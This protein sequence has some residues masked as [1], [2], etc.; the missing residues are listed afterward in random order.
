MYYTEYIYEKYTEYIHEKEQRMN[1][2]FKFE[3]LN[4]NEL[5]SSK[6]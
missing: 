5:V 2:A 3:S 6:I 1:S 4:D